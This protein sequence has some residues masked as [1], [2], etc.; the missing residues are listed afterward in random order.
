MNDYTEDYAK[1]YNIL[2]GH[3]NYDYETRVLCDILA[4]YIDPP[5]SNLLSVGCGT[6]SHEKFLA[7]S[8]NTVLGIDSSPG[9]I[10]VG[11]ESQ[12]ALNLRLQHRS[13]ESVEEQFEV[14]VSLFNVINCIPST[15]E[16]LEFFKSVKKCAAPKGI[17]VFEA[18]NGIDTIVNPPQ[19]VSRVFSDSDMRLVRDATPLLDTYNA[20]LRIDYA[21]SGVNAGTQVS[22]KSQHDIYLHTQPVINEL[23]IEAG[24]ESLQWL[25]ALSDGA[26]P[27]LPDTRMLLCVART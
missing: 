23:L 26:D 16:L 12:C 24:F 27:A 2:T 6:G 17:F 9:M 13:L 7:N 19:T 20:K 11:N 21:I 25:S 18:W 5:N 10:S 1:Y 22:L 14:V 3:K 8:F 4:N 15:I